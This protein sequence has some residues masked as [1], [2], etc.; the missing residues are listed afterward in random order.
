MEDNP[1]GI[2]LGIWLLVWIIKT[3][4]EAHKDG[5]LY[6]DHWY[7]GAGSNDGMRD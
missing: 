1:I 7:G 6:K 2:F 3:L 5:S 4:V